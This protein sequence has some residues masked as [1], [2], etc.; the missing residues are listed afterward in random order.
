[1][2]QMLPLLGSALG[3]E[4][5]GTDGRLREGQAGRA[6]TARLLGLHAVQ[7][8]FC[9]FFGCLFVH[10]RRGLASSAGAALLL[11]AFPAAQTGP[12]SFHFPPP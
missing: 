6:C 8:R 5:V 1:M 3:H 9:S 11:H 12:F 10:P 2:L 4:V 7:E